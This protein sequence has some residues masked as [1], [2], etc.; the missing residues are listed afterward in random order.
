MSPTIDCVIFDLGGVLVELD[1]PPLASEHSQLSEPEIWQQWL[2]SSAVR[3]FESG[4]SHPEEFATALIS[5]MKLDQTTE[6]FLSYFKDWPRGFYT[7]A[8]ALLGELKQSVQV[9]CL[10]NTNQLHWDRFNQ[11]SNVISQFD[12][13][14]ASF[15]TAHLKPDQAA[16]IH[17]IYSLDMLPE[18]LLFFDDNPTNIQAAKAAGM[19]AELTRGPTEAAAHLKRYGLL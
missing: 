11:E 1:G 7:G 16:F 15:E 13:V 18:R 6:S 8:E 3:R 9:A 12:F 17:A 14:F 2:H 4:R 19:L 5:E 10:S